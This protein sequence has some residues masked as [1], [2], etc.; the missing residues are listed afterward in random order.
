[1]KLYEVADN[2]TAG[3]QKLVASLE[4]SVASAFVFY[5]KAHSFHWNVE[6]E[7]FAEYHK[8]FGEIYEDV[9]ESIDAFAEHLR[10]LDAPAPKSLAQLV[11]QSTVGESNDNLGVDQMKQ[12]LLNDNE[13]VIKALNNTMA[14]ATKRDKQG[15]MNFLAG[16]I[17][18]HNKWSWFLR[19]STKGSK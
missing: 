14:E 6:G 5:F 11:K 7:Q 17:E 2:I 19:A 9:Y 12:M 10:A 1:M 15:L 18:Q 8:M 3:S 13:Q 4:K 16:R